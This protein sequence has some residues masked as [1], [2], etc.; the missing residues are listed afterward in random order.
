MYRSE[1]VL[2]V[3]IGFSHSSL[4]SKVSIKNKFYFF[5]MRDLKKWN[6]SMYFILRWQIIWTRLL[7]D[8]WNGDWLF[9]IDL[10]LQFRMKEWKTQC[11]FNNLAL[12]VLCPQKNRFLVIH[13]ITGI[14][15]L[16]KQAKLKLLKKKNENGRF[17]HCSEKR[18]ETNRYEYLPILKPTWSSKSL[19]AVI[20]DLQRIMYNLFRGYFAQTSQDWKSW[21]RKHLPRFL[22]SLNLS[23]RAKMSLSHKIEGE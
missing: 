12:Q 4:Q 11:I 16:D 23:P 22:V 6:H 14:T 20:E 5:Y 8:L 2:F 15:P 17:C 10:F 9:S 21:Y 13:L 7:L 3:H 19:A 1:R 18:C